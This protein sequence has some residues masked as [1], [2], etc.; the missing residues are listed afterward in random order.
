MCALVK[1]AGGETD[2][3]IERERETDPDEMGHLFCSPPDVGLF[4]L[5]YHIS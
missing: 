4:C 1:N 2:G 3:E 5:S